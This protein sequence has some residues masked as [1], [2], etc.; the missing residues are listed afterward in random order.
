[1]DPLERPQGVRPDRFDSAATD[2][3]PAHHTAGDAATVDLADLPERIASDALGNDATVGTYLI[4][5]GR[6]EH[7][8]R[9]LAERLGYTQEEVVGLPIETLVHPDDRFTVMSKIRDRVEGR[10]EQVIYSFRALTRDGGVVHLETHGARLFSGSAATIGGIVVDVTDRIHALEALQISERRFAEI[11]RL[12]RDATIC[13][14]ADLSVVLFNPAAEA[15]FGYSTGDAAGLSLQSLFPELEPA[16][17]RNRTPIETLIPPGPPRLVQGRRRDGSR[18]WAEVSSALAAGGSQDLLILMVR[19]MTEQ[20]RKEEEREAFLE[21]ERERRILAESS[22]MRAQ[23]LAEVSSRLSS[24]LPD[25]GVLLERLPEL[26]IPVLADYAAVYAEGA[27]Q[28]L[29]PVAV[30]ASDPGV[31]DALHVSPPTLPDLP[32]DEENHGWVFRG[33]STEGLPPAV[34]DLGRA[35]ARILGAAAVFVLPLRDGDR[36]VGLLLLGRTGTVP[37]SQHAADWDL[38]RELAHRASCALTNARLYAEARQAVELRDQVLAVVSHE[39]RNPLNVVDFTADTMLRYWPE[40]PEDLAAARN[41]FGVLK[42]SAERMKRL[43]RD[44]LDVAQIQQGTLGI[45]RVPCDS[46][47][48]LRE[49]YNLNRRLAEEQGIRLDLEVED[50]VPAVELD[51]ERILQVLSN[52]VENALRHTP[53]EKAIRLRG[54]TREGRL[55]VEVVDEGPGVDPQDHQ[56]IFTRFAK[57]GPPRKAGAGLG[58]AIAAGIVAAHGG[59]IGVEST[60]G[61]GATFYFTIP[62]SEQ[63][64]G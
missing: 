3:E 15:L 10:A 12:A 64:G 38:A 26:A 46:A 37:E 45:D 1:M 22:R 28:T 51:G 5:D 30:A 13:L 55:R 14:E 43:V 4:V 24:S 17:G 62:A 50:D 54:L 48:L 16:V 32:W 36:I 35:H 59:E 33:S 29:A 49:A 56:R 42:L 23:F 34:R 27:D 9:Y 6:F 2:G 25:P 7:V 19:D 41:Q 47:A 52:L 60:P 18:F 57:A 31:G 44:L 63:P 8:N 39:L 61:A 40:T 20:R 53:P 21:L 58:L 11:F